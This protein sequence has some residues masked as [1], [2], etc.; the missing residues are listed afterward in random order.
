MEHLA[1]IMEENLY[2][3]S[4]KHAMM[5]A[6]QG[7]RVFLGSLCS[8]EAF[9]LHPE[10]LRIMEDLPQKIRRLRELQ[11]LSQEYLANHLDVSRQTYSRIESGK[12]ELT[13]NRLKKIASVLHC[14]LDALLSMSAEAAYMRFVFDRED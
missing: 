6:F 1:D 8:S 13:L 7:K 4:K 10:I 5:S 9:I 3:M 14:P 11:N 12:T 2:R